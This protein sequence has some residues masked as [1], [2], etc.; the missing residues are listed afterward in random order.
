MRRAARCAG[1]RTVMWFARPAGG[2]A[3]RWAE[4]GRCSVLEE[5]LP[6]LWKR[7]E[8]VGDKGLE[9]V[10]DDPESGLRRDDLGREGGRLS[11]DRPRLVR[12]ALG[13]RERVDRVH[14]RVRQG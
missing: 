5:Q 1:A 6:V 11:L 12:F 4:R 8:V 2:P 9:I 14:E 10:D 13:M 7:P 3:G